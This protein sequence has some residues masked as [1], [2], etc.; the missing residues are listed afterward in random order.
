MVGHTCHKYFEHLFGY[1]VD[2]Y[3]VTK[4]SA[5]NLTGSRM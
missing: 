1:V 3:F 2:V 4:Q 5:E